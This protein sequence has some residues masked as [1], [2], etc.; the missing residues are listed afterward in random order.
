MKYTTEEALAEIMRRS[1]GIVLRRNRRSCRRL[2]GAAGA[3]FAVLVLVIALLPGRTE[4]ASIGSVYGSFL[5]SAESGGYV[6]ASV[7]A[8]TLGV[9]VTLL[10]LKM[11][12]QKLQG[13]PDS[14]SQKDHFAESNA[15]KN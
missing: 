1:E 2:S 5:L 13:N 9:V 3:L 7:I 12:K 11:K 15:A 6:L 14:Q 10:C 4:A 8:F